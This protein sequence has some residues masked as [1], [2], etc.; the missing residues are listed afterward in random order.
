LAKENTSSYKSLPESKHVS[1]TLQDV[2]AKLDDSLGEISAS[3]SAKFSGFGSASFPGRLNS[4]Y[5]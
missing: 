4:K 2:K 3:N 1:S 5:Y